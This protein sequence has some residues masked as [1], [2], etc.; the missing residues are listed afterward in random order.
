[1]PERTCRTCGCT[2]ANACVT[3]GHPCHWVEPDLCSRCADTRIDVGLKVVAAEIVDVAI[4]AD[5]KLETTLAGVLE[6]GTSFTGVWPGEWHLEPTP[7]TTE[8]DSE[9]PDQHP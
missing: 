9:Q 3:D 7:T 1:M 6:D 5:G 4:L 2:D 8:D